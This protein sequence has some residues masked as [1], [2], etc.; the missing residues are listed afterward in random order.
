M[1]GLIL[2]GFMKIRFQNQLLGFALFGTINEDIASLFLTALETTEYKIFKRS[3][4]ILEIFLLLMNQ[5][6]IIKGN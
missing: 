3:V 5:A 4:L 1:R 2:I 6:R